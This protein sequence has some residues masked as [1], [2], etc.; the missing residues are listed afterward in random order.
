MHRAIARLSQST[1]SYRHLVSEKRITREDVGPYKGKPLQLPL[2]DRTVVIFGKPDRAMF[3]ID[4]EFILNHCCRFVRV[5]QYAM[6]IVGDTHCLCQL[7]R[8]HAT[9]TDRHTHA[10][11]CITTKYNYILEACRH[12]TV[13]HSVV[14]RFF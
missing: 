7:F 2:L 12:V 10:M 9:F 4:Y 5:D 13:H 3:D 14:K 1:V 6:C 11:K 8:T